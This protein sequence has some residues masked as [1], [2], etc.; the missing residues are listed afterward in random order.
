MVLAVVS[1]PL[2]IMCK[3]TDKNLQRACLAGCY[4]TQHS[5]IKTRFCS[6]AALH[7]KV[8]SHLCVIPLC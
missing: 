3:E 6:Q 5:T 8:Q 4:R 1:R 2:Q 7:D